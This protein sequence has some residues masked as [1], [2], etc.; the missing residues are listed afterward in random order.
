MQTWFDIA[1]HVIRLKSRMSQW[2]KKIQKTT[3]DKEKKNRKSL[4][5]VDHQTKI[6]CHDDNL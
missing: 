5:N 1:W 6:I 4:N 2:R 3:Q